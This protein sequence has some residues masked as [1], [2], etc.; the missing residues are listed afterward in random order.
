MAKSCH[1]NNEDEEAARHYDRR[2][3]P[4]CQHRNSSSHMRSNRVCAQ[5][6]S[7]RTI[8]FLGAGSLQE[9]T[10]GWGRGAYT[11]KTS[12]HSQ[13]GRIILFK[14]PTGWNRFDLVLEHH[15]Q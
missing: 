8:G 9:F 4:L 15:S 6:S 3:K 2:D 12:Q 7:V 11:F 5:Q 14:N 13:R 10:G 1:G